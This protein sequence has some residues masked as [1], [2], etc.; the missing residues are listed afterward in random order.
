MKI[1]LHVHTKERSPC[2][3]S[4]EEEMIQAGIDYGLDGLVFTDHHRL[5]PIGR[6]KELNRR[7]APFR[8]FG[9]VEISVIEGEDILVLGVRDT[10]LESRDWSYP[11]LFAF[12]RE[13]EGFLVLAHPFRFHDSVDIDLMTYPPDAVELHSNNIGVCD[14]PR[15]RDLLI[16]VELFPVCNSDAHSAERVGIYYNQLL[17]SPKDEGDLMEI[18]RTGQY[19]CRG[20]QERISAFNGEI[21][22]QERLIRDLIVKGYSRDDYRRM[23]GHG[24]GHYDRVVM[25]KSYQI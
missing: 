20:M 17:R 25:G 14:E 5:I 8:I 21:K 12:V 9:G 2:G 24:A 6:L 10:R 7:Y 15:I 19:T 18:L 22:E 3:R 23:T 1:D 13:R 11:D 4:S 16:S